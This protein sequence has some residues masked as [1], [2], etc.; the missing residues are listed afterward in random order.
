MRLLLSAT[1]KVDQLLVLRVCSANSRIGAGAA[2]VQRQL[3]SAAR[4]RPV[5]YNW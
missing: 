1:L 5:S 4:V 3:S 2:A